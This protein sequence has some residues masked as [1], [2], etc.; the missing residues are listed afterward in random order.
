M[1]NKLANQNGFWSAKCWNWSEN[2]QLLY[3][4][5]NNIPWVSELW[6]SGLWVSGWIAPKE[7][8]RLYCILII[9]QEAFL[10]EGYPDS[11]ST[12]YLTYQKWDTLQVNWL[13][14][15]LYNVL[16]CY[17]PS[18]L[19]S[20]EHLLLMLCWLELV[21]ETIKLLRQLLLS[22]GYSKVLLDNYI[23]LTIPTNI[24][25]YILLTIPTNICNYILLTIPTNIYAAPPAVVVISHY[26]E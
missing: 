15:Q 4:T 12:D 26:K 8:V 20:L 21:L 11:V 25:N 14:K 2:G 17:R 22:H 23:L 7:H 18:V 9:V 19:V 13:D 16:L 24:C 10:P 5:L 6:V 1:Y 3:L